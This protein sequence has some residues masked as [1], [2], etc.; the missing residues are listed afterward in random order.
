MSGGGVLGVGSNVTVTDN[1]FTLDWAVSGGGI[2]LTLCD[3]VVA[4][5]TFVGNC[6]DGGGGAASPL[7]Q[8]QHKQ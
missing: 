7:H 5:N 6:T 3:A 4:N 2:Y 8:R 1:L